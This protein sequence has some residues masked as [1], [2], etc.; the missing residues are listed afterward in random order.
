MMD[1]S[2]ST[3][4]QLAEI[5][6]GLEF[7]PTLATASPSQLYVISRAV[8]D[9]AKQSKEFHDKLRTAEQERDQYRKWLAEK[10]SER[11]ELVEELESL[12]AKIKEAQEP[13]SKVSV[14]ID[15][16][17]NDGELR[18]T[19]NDILKFTLR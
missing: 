7:P 5:M 18:N 16:Y 15:G 13:I 10:N 9:Q 2:I 19:S 6:R 14:F 12:R 17:G 4:E 1:K 11:D 3:V 8:C